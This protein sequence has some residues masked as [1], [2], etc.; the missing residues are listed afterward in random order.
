VFYVI[1][2]DFDDGAT[3]AHKNAIDKSSTVDTKKD[4]VVV[5]QAYLQEETETR[6]YSIVPHSGDVPA[7]S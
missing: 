7:P 1:W 5:V 2:E 4:A 6:T 3:L